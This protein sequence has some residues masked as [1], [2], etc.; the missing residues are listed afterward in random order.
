[1]PRPVKSPSSGKTQSQLQQQQQAGKR[2]RDARK[3]RG[4]R[5]EDLAEAAGVTGATVSRWETGIYPIPEMGLT[6]L[7]HRL[8]LNPAHI[9]SGVTPVWIKPMPAW[10]TQEAIASPFLVDLGT[11]HLHGASSILR[12]RTLVACRRADG[13]ER[14]GLYACMTPR[15]ILIGH[16]WPDPHGVL[17]IYPPDN[18]ELRTKGHFPPIKVQE[19]DLIGAVFGLVADLPAAKKT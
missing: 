5:L 1:M 3:E 10:G 2:L 8:G 13:L 14:G 19:R 18:D 6:A 11:A 16:L 12:D 9:T 4:I 15:G 7:Q 17:Y